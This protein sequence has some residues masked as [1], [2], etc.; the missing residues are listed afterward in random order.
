MHTREASDFW[1]LHKNMNCVF[2]VIYLDLIY[3]YGIVND[4]KLTS[5]GILH[6]LWSADLSKVFS[7]LIFSI[8]LFSLYYF[9]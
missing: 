5:H 8:L 6:Y 9:Q 2:N 4:L 1:G 3:Y 7:Q